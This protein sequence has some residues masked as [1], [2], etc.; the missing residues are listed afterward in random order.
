VMYRRGV[1]ATRV[2]RTPGKELD[3]W[4][5]AELDAILADVAPLMKVYTP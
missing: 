5:R 2:C 4:D 3:D 1:I